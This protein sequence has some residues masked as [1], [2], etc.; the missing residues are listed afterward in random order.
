MCQELRY[1]FEYGI[2]C[3]SRRAGGIPDH[4]YDRRGRI[5]DALRKD[6]R[7]NYIIFELIAILPRGISSECKTMRL[8]MRR[9]PTIPVKGLVQ[10]HEI[11]KLHNTDDALQN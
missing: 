11:A 2:T 1:V 3:P 9:C 8:P 5:Y 4:G 7:K 6:E 10:Q